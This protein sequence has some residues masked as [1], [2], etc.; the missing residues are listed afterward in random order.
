MN[1]P[2]QFKYLA[3]CFHPRS[4]EEHVTVEEWVRSTV[5]DFLSPEDRKVVKLFLDELLSGATTDDDL[6]KIW[7]AAGFGFWHTSAEGPRSFMQM[8]RDAS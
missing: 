5:Q 1:V 6:Q 7:R 3:T 8:I 4:D 2:Q